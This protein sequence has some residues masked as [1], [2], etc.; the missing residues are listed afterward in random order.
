[1]SGLDT[2]RTSG[3]REKRFMRQLQSTLSGIQEKINDLSCRMEEVEKNVFGH[4]MVTEFTSLEEL[5]EI[6]GSLGIQGYGLM[7]KETLVKRIY[8]EYQNSKISSEDSEEFD[9]SDDPDDPDDS[10][11]DIEDDIDA[12]MVLND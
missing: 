6:A 5:K 7:K 3:E 8:E 10:D 9:D 2:S 4:K 1:V 11:R 12:D